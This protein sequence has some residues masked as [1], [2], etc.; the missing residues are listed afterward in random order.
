M[1]SRYSTLVISSALSVLLIGCRASDMP[2]VQQRNTGTIYDTAHE[3][4]LD[5]GKALPLLE[6]AWRSEVPLYAE[7][8]AIRGWDDGVSTWEIFFA[9]NRGLDR[10]A[11]DSRRVGFGNDLSSKPLFGQAH[12][13]L[14]R[15]R[16]GV[17]PKRESSNGG[18]IATLDVVE[19]LPVEEF[20]DGVTRQVDRS[21]QKDVLVFVHGFNVDFDASLVRT[22]QISLDMPFNGAVVAYS[23]PSLGGVKHYGDDEPRNAK[24]VAPFLE[25]LTALRDGLPQE[26][27]LHVF[28]HSMGNRIVL[29][30][31]SR[32]TAPDGSPP[33]DN[34]A[35]LAPDVGVDDF[36]RWAPAAVK[37]C[38]RVTLYAS[39]NDAALIASKSLHAEQRAG[40][41][42][43]PVIVD[44][45]ETVDC[46][47]IDATSFMGHSYYS[48]NVDVLADL[49]E[50]VKRDRA[51]S[52]RGHLK[53]KKSS[54]GPY[55]VWT[56]T[57]PRDIWTWH[58]DHLLAEQE[59]QRN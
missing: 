8:V 30:A 39:Q 32:L 50:L 47:A 48:S 49:F 19:Q 52:K 3:K 33:I 1:S 13:T 15:R 16:R 59:T 22:A 44:G 34:L 26:T 38:R 46:S 20:L 2:I 27:K 5:S 42:Y 7:P 24:S 43:P 21:R 28:V 25:F 57:A 55:W 4:L 35:L 51:A 17:D 29:A 11:F 45:I 54:A 10:T 9:T 37:Q 23:W 12:V 58:F 36:R 40:D 53:R 6:Q 14:P 31:L 18:D 56:A 41:A